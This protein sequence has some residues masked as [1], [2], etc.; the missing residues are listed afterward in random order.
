MW[1][2]H[3]SAR[4]FVL[5]LVLGTCADPVVDFVLGSYRSGCFVD[6]PSVFCSHGLLFP[7]LSVR[8]ECTHH[9]SYSLRQSRSDE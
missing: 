4:S 5:P 1:P 8:P 2:A 3:Q 6:F 9:A 7:F